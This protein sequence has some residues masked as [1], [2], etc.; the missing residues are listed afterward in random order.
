MA[1]TKTTTTPTET[2]PTKKKKNAGSDTIERMKAAQLAKSEPSTTKLK[3]AQA[4]YDADKASSASGS[5]GKG[6]FKGGNIDLK[7]KLDAAKAGK[8]KS[9]KDMQR[10]NDMVEG[11]EFGANVLGPDGLG[12]LGTDSEVQESLGRFK[13][14]AD[15]G[16]SREEVAAERAQATRSIDSSTQTGMRSLQ[17]RLSKMGVKGTVAGQQLIQ[18]EMGGAQQK[19]DLAQNLFLKSESIKRE[20]LKDFSQRQ[21]DIKQFDL[22][23]SAKEKDIIMQS[24]ISFAQLGSSERTARYAADR[25]KEASVASARASKPSCFR[26]TNTVTD[27]KGKLVYFKDMKPGML[28]EDGN[29][30]TGISKHI[31]VDDLYNYKG[32][33][34]TGCHYVLDGIGFRQVRNTSESFQVEYDLKE[35]YVYNVFTSSGLITV[36]GQIFSDYDD[37]EL[38]AIDEEICSLPQREVQ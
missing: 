29:I 37:D 13:D 15:K 36:N 32:A 2:A 9:D 4:A 30:V 14:I 10:G 27:I 17:A 35:L 18:R 34:V 12:R 8:A 21:G 16:L 23:Q 24:G 28:L 20:G 7:N 6:N 3:E 22:G 5:K 19:A 31:A 25:S 38:K 33:F 26:G 11:A 1:E